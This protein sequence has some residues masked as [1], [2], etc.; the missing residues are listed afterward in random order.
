MSKKP[1]K[2]SAH[3]ASNPLR[4]EDRWRFADFELAI[5]SRELRRAGKPVGIE[6]KPLNLL[7]LLLRAPG[8]LVT[9]EELIEALW[10]GRVV[11]DGVIT[12]CINKLRLALGDEGATLVK[13]VHG[14]GY[15]FVGQAE[16]LSVAAGPQPSVWAVGDPVPHRPHWHFQ[17]ALAG[18]SEAWVAQ[19]HKTGERRVFKFARDAAQLRALK[20]EVTLYRL[21]RETLGGSAPIA[22][23]LDYQMD[24]PPC[25][26]ELEYCVD[27]SLLDW[28][29]R[30]GP[31]SSLQAR[32]QWMIQ[33]AEAVA[34]IHAQGVLHKDL[35]PA[36]FLLDRSDSGHTRL[37]L[38]D[39]GCGQIDLPDRL[40]ALA[41]T[42]LGL[43]EEG[44]MGSDASGTRL[45]L[46]PELLAGQ[47]RSQRSDMFSLGVML[48]QMVVG[49]P[50][51]GLA[52][53]W[54]RDVGDPL[55]RE[56]IAAAAERD[57]LRRMADAAELALRL[58]S[59]EARRIERAAM[60]RQQVENRLALE[61]L[62]R[63][64]QRQ[65]WLRALAASL[66]LG[67]LGT[68]VMAV[69][70]QM[71]KQAAEAAAAEAEHLNDFLNDEVLAAADPFRAGGGR[72]VRVGTLLD[73]AA[74][75]LP[76]LAGQ[77][78]FHARLSLTVAK[79]YANLG[80]GKEAEDIL[81][82]TLQQQA[83]RL[84]ESDASLRAIR[85][86]LAWIAVDDAH[87]E[88][89]RQQFQTLLDTAGALP[90]P[91]RGAALRDARYGLARLTYEEGG[92]EPSVALYRALLAETTDQAADQSFRNDVKWDLAEALM[93]TQGWDE[94]WVLLAEVEQ[95]FAETGGIDGPRQ[96]WL[97]VSQ[98]YWLQMHE[99][100]DEAESLF[101]KAHRDS[102]AALG[103]Q[104][105]LV[106]TCQQFLGMLRVKQGQ[107]KAA[108]PYFETVL[109]WRQKHYREG[110]HLTNMT[111]LRIGE[112]LTLDGRARE[113]IPQLQQLVIDSTRVLGEQH[114]HTLDI[115]RTLAEA[116]LMAGHADQAETDFR[117][118]LQRGSGLPANN[119][120]LTWA[121]YGLSRSLLAQ[122]Q[123]EAATVMLASVQAEFSR[124][125][126]AQHS[127]ALRIRQQLDPAAPK[128][129][130]QLAERLS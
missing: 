121:R 126:G 39:F 81:K 51:R 89:A 79:A 56:D 25:F 46:A 8:E 107:A 4:A 21:L 38:A 97:K 83:A 20:R 124:H 53:G 77:P 119:N 93:E 41:I 19:Q 54:E 129:P 103:S 62:Q 86:R 84:G 95:Y 82:T 123:T 58:K 91:R 22:R 87:Y 96:Q 69:R 60:E 1:I 112:A 110:H 75:R 111:R 55:L 94:A 43:T 15:R 52:P 31:A 80:L 40:D 115:L 14:Y 120:R 117:L 26:I 102:A 2:P 36:N 113:A 85:D 11:T 100:W 57:P 88:E 106:I 37:V 68:S 61:A 122:G 13:T 130:V 16:R 49:D 71:S 24:E 33:A 114:P 104:H 35:K 17:L 116:E 50:Q 78:A 28:L 12:N 127:V 98:G 9:K 105:P 99:R 18:A 72:E 32:L 109:A 108:L 47:P 59:L 74:Q 29:L 63:V 128:R 65:P 92:F 10:D 101:Q 30:D 5:A 66:V 6:P 118:V 76:S 42:R 67:L 45:Y 3:V 73:Q 48:Y 23:L 27:G 44:L 64:R 125:F 7:L 34:V 70:A 90:E